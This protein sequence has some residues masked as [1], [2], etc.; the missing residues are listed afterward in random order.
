MQNRMNRFV[1]RA[2]Q[3]EIDMSLELTK[4]VEGKTIRV[5][6]DAIAWLI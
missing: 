5:F 1:G 3:F 6:R 4:Q 2:H